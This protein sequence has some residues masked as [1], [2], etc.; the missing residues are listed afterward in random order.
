MARGNGARAVA[1]MAA[2]HVLLTVAPSRL[3]PDVIAQTAKI[4]RQVLPSCGTDRLM[5]VWA[6]RL[7][8]ELVKLDAA[9]MAPA[10]A[11]IQALLKRVEMSDDL[12]MSTAAYA[13]AAFAQAMPKDA[14]AFKSGRMSESGVWT[15]TGKFDVDFEDEYNSASITY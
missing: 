14:A 5:A 9:H 3:E 10:S 13:S 6:L 8:A 11:D 7:A 12:M 1:G 2:L 4:V 15:E